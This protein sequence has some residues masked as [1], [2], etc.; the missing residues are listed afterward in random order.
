MRGKRVIRADGD[1]GGVNGSRLTGGGVSIPKWE[2]RSTPDAE[3]V[4]VATPSRE[5][6][7]TFLGLRL[8][9][10]SSSLNEVGFSVTKNPV[11]AWQEYA[12]CRRSRDK[13]PIWVLNYLASCAQQIEKLVECSPTIKVSAAVA[14]AIGFPSGGRV[15]AVR[16]SYRVYQQR[17][18]LAL[19]VDKL[20]HE[21]RLK[22]TAAY[23]E[24][25]K[26]FGVGLTT[27]KDAY[28]L[29]QPHLRPHLR[30]STPTPTE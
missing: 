7:A 4:R 11:F 17:V 22:P 3:R 29:L 8:F 25:A 6:M 28:T 12:R 15:N 20:I 30:R 24:A 5:Q 19:S 9:A 16:V 21:N 2:A 10:D 18:I 26:A 13:V 27:A 1:K 23:K 14:K